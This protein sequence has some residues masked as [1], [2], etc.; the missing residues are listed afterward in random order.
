MIFGTQ[1]RGLETGFGLLNL[2]QGGQKPKTKISF[3]SSKS[4]KLN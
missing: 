3:F 2:H 4:K 1:G